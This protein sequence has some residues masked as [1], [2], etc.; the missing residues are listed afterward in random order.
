[1]SNTSFYA[2]IA[3]YIDGTTIRIEQN[4]VVIK[5]NFTL[6]YGEVYQWLGNN[7]DDDITGAKVISDN[8]VSVMSG[9]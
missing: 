1:V 7:L 9:E 2:V 8:K 5:S 4:G 6:D 3:S